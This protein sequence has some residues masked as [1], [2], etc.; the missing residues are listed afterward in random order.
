M[1]FAII[2]DTPNFI[3]DLVEHSYDKDDIIKFLSFPILQGLIQKRLRD[4]G[5]SSHP[6]LCAELIYSNQNKLG[7]FVDSERLDLIDKLSR[8]MGV[9]TIEVRLS[10]SGKDEK[11]VDMMVFVRMLEY[12]LISRPY[13]YHNV[14]IGSDRD[15]VPAMQLLRELGIHT[16]LLGFMDKCPNEQIN[17]SYLFINL[18]ELIDDMIQEVKQSTG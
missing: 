18:K 11:G 15:Y 16:I 14:L 5:L 8:Q 9:T 13:L 10:K 7:P 12:G 3:N 6:F 1:G 2:V 4:N 17:E